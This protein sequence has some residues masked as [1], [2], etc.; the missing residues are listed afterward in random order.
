MSSSALTTGKIS[1][2]S[3]QFLLSNGLDYDFK[4]NPDKVLN[5]MITKI[6]GDAG[7]FVTPNDNV[8]DIVTVLIDLTMY[9]A[10]RVD[11]D[12]AI[13]YWTTCSYYSYYFLFKDKLKPTYMAN[14]YLETAAALRYYNIA[15][16]EIFSYL[17]K[18]KIRLSSLPVLPCV[19]GEIEFRKLNSDLKWTPD[20][21]KNFIVCYDYLPKFFK[22]HTFSPGIGVP[23]IGE[24][25]IS[26]Q[27]ANPDQYTL[28][29]TVYPFTFLIEYR[30]HINNLR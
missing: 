5:L 23:I 3:R 27:I 20:T 28:L 15:T 19:I 29:H 21:F 14:F 30:Y 12:K 16:S 8:R 25:D 18:K 6:H 10:R 4:H 24:N 2:L 9:Q 11:E 26:S 1:Y 7:Y 17:I 13:K 22:S